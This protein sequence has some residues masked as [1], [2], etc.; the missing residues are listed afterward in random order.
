MPDSEYWKFYKL[1]GNLTAKILTRVSRN[2][3]K[4]I[5]AFVQCNGEHLQRVFWTLICILC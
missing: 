2:M 4:R 3:V 1:I 5:D